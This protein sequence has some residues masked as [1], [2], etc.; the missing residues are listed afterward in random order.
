MKKNEWLYVL[1]VYSVIAL[2]IG[3]TTNIEQVR[4]EERQEIDISLTPKEVLF[5]VSDMKPGDWANRSIR[6]NNEGIS[7]LIYIMKSEAVD[8]S[9]ELYEALKIAVKDKEKILYEGS[10]RD[11]EK[12]KGRTLAVGQSDELTYTVR[13]PEELGNEYQGLQTKVKFIFYA[14]GANGSSGEI[15]D[16]NGTGNN[17][18]GSS[19]VNPGNDWQLPRTGMQQTNMILLGIGLILV[20]F[21]LY[22]KRMKS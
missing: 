9:N 22:R 15:G 8:G 3:I 7:K 6:V 12:M 2:L 20:G 4:A 21:Y 19:T 10:L 17:Q 16:G 5:H 18:S 11:F 14:E 13:V 1:V